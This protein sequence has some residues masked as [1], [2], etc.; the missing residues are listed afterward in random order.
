M[1]NYH[2]HLNFNDWKREYSHLSMKGLQSIARCEC[3]DLNAMGEE[4][5]YLP[6]LCSLIHFCSKQ[7]DAENG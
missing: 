5:D 1:K 6:V 3:I 4:C 2:N 7:E